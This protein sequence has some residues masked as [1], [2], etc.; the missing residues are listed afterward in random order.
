MTTDYHARLFAH[1][2]RRRHSVS[3]SEKLAG[4]LLDA[5][6]DSTLKTKALA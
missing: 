5:Q 2:P 1:E 6:V 4:A 3:D